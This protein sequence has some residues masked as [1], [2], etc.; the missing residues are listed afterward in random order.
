M[1]MQ[2]KLVELSDL[3]EPV[4]TKTFPKGKFELFRVG[5]RTFG[6]ATYEPGWKWSEHVGPAV[7]DS[8]CRLSHFGY[9]VS[10]SAAASFED[11]SVAE[12]RA[13]AFFYIPPIAHDSWV[14]GNEPYVSL[15]LDHP[16]DYAAKGN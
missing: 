6:R 3:L 15:H 10:G 9:V 4:E 5:D 11:G 8:L 7:D 16:E 1:T 13:G 14:I 12:L 2:A